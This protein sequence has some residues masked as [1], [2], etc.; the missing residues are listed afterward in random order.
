MLFGDC[1]DSIEP[2]DEP[3]LWA[4][5]QIALNTLETATLQF[6]KIV[7][8]V[9]KIEAKQFQE[10]LIVG[11]KAHYGYTSQEIE[12]VMDHRA[13]QV[14]HDAMK[15]QDIIAGKAKAVAKTKKAK[16]ALKAGAKKVKDSS[17]KVRERQKAKLRRSGSIDDALD[18]MLNS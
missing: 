8:A 6:Q 4:D 2:M 3:D 15:Y 5:F 10:K 13:I 1:A 16:P 14:L 12:Q 7:K 9:W 18:L 11:G 17:N